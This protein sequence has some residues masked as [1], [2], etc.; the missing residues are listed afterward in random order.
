[1]RESIWSEA[2]TMGNKE[3]EFLRSFRLIDRVLHFAF[4]IL[5]LVCFASSLIC[6]GGM[7]WIVTSPLF[8]DGSFDTG[9]E[10]VLPTAFSCGFYYYL[11]KGSARCAA[12]FGGLP[13]EDSG[14]ANE[15]L[16]ETLGNVRRLT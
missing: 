14:P 10:I 16:E 7:I 2:D 6:F 1:M 12:F 4:W 3:R 8:V 11:G 9:L 5:S 13:E 15:P